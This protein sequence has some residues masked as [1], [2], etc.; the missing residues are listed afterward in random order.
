MHS[1]TSLLTILFLGVLTIGVT[2]SLS[3]G[4]NSAMLAGNM[5]ILEHGTGSPSDICHNERKSGSFDCR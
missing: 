2:P 5:Q 1:K 3:V 4:A